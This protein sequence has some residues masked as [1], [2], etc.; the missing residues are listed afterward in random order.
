MHRLDRERVPAPPCLAKYRPGTHRWEDLDPL[1]KVEIHRHLEAFQGLRCAYCEASLLDFGRHIEHFRR[2]QLF[3]HLTFVW[4]N[5]FWSCDHPDCCGC[6]K[7]QK[8]SDYDPDDLID[9]V[10]DDPDDYFRFR[11]DGSIAPRS[12]LGSTD[13]RRAETT[14]AVFNLDPGKGRLRTLRMLK[15]Q[16]YLALDPSLVE[17]LES[18]SADE[19]DEF[20][21][22][23]I[24]AI[25][26]EPFWTV[27]RHLFIDMT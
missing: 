22:A 10:K 9:P 23:E 16:S 11:S 17:A 27:V 2:R 25:A 24:E 7:D 4:P 3:Q 14:L 5:L 20:I 12:G 1:D 26:H 13:L 15:A 19:R 8:H 6:H 18:F 21:R